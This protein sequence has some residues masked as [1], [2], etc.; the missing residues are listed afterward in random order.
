MA[1]DVFTLNACLAISGH[2]FP[3]R[4][5]ISLQYTLLFYSVSAVSTQ[6]YVRD[7]SLRVIQVNEETDET[8]VP[9]V[10]ISR[11][12]TVIF[13]IVEYTIMRW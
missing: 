6:R 5:C 10:P 12:R 8:P 7:V 2:N 4:S 3:T 9:P 13:D 1:E 11:G